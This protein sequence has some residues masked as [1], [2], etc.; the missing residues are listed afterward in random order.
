[1]E[2]SLGFVDVVSWFWI[3]DG[4][5]LALFR[6]LLCVIAADAGCGTGRQER[7]QV[8]RPPPVSHWCLWLKA[9]EECLVPSGRE[10]AAAA[11]SG[12]RMPSRWPW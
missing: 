7:W 9:P 5:R 2:G 1:M 6:M 8:S 12:A 3:V 10:G 4:R 11:R